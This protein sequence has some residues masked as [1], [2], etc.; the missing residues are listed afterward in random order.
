MIRTLRAYFFRRHLREKL[1]IAALVLLVALLWLSS[2]GGRAGRFFTDERETSMKLAEQKQ[3]LAHRS[4]IQQNAAKAAAIFDPSRTLDSTQLLAAVNAIA[5]DAG[6]NSTTS[7]ED[8]QDISNGQFAVHSL[9]FNITRADWASLTTFY[10]A[11]QQR[12]PYIGVEQ[13]QLARDRANPFLAQCQHEDFLGRD[14]AC[15]RLR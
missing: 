11:L 5:H 3:W 2:L 12:A 9:Q 6:L 10:V 7:G 15:R 4:V 14:R 13:F 8:V 1:L